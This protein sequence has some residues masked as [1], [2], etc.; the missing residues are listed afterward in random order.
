MLARKKGKRLDDLVC[1]EKVDEE[2]FSDYS[3]SEMDDA[4]GRKS[5]ASKRRAELT[6][7]E[8]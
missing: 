2:F 8:K 5:A 4:S 3:D 6:A 1:D 7:L